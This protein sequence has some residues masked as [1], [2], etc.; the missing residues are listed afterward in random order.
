MFIKTITCYD[1]RYWPDF[2]HIS[3]IHL[4][5]IRAFTIISMNFILKLNTEG[6][7][8]QDSFSL[9]LFTAQ[10]PFQSEKTLSKERPNAPPYLF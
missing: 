8:K 5:F 2:E 4:P 3:L 1:V 9:K 10:E 7:L 6:Q